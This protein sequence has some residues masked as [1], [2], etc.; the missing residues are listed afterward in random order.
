MAFKDRPLFRRILELDDLLRQG[1]K[2]NASILAKRFETS[3]KTAQRLIDYMR[4]EFGAPI[5]WDAAGCRYTYTDADF[6]LPW[7]PVDGKDLFAVGVAMKVLQMYDGTPAAADLKVIF[8][9]L[10]ELMPA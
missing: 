6:H 7:L 8:E 3:V 9:R 1:K 2:V 4:D 5:E 10:S